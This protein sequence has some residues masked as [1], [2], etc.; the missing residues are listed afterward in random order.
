MAS[1]PSGS[2]VLAS[3]AAVPPAQPPPMAG[4]PSGTGDRAGGCA[5]GAFSARW[6]AL[7]QV[8]VGVGKA[9]LCWLAR[10]G[11]SSSSSSI[12]VRSF[13]PNTRGDAP[14]MPPAACKWKGV[15]SHV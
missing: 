10:H 1:W 7:I 9:A 3:A 8:S 2:H 11:D 12:K 5:G 15:D 4:G 13:G 6:P 14:D